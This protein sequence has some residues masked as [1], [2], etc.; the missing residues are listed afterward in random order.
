MLPHKKDKLSKGTR[1]KNKEQEPGTRN[2]NR[3]QEQEP[4]FAEWAR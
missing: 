1:N 4:C 3:N 2:R